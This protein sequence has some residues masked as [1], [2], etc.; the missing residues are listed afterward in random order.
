MC[1]IT[2]VPANIDIP[3]KGIENGAVFNDD[4]HGWAVASK[5]GLEVG[6]SMDYDIAAL[7]LAVAREKHGPDSLVLFH[8]RFATHG[9]KTEFNVHPFFVD[10]DQ[11]SVYDE[12]D[13]TD[14]T[15]YAP[16]D[17]VMAH[18][19]ILPSRWQPTASDVRSDT[20]IFGDR[21]GRLHTQNGVPSRRGGKAMGQMIGLGNKLVFLTAKDGNPKVRI[22]NAHL[23]VFTE[24]VWYSNDGYMDHFWGGWSGGSHWSSDYTSSGTVTSNGTTLTTVEDTDG[25]DLPSGA[26]KDQC[27]WCKQFDT[28]DKASDTCAACE[29]CLSCNEWMGDCDCY[30]SQSEI[31]AKQSRHDAQMRGKG[32]ELWTPT[33]SPLNPA[34]KPAEAGIEV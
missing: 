32:V 2:Y 9:K 24:G 11:P 34:F 28:I 13:E 1:M 18:N 19:G 25:L 8:S 4:G 29:V 15:E 7:T 3:W 26:T 14:E 20:R 21:I 22:V 6:K 10:A 16:L 31:E 33:G 30:L 27:P 17:T 5:H 23:G 12:A